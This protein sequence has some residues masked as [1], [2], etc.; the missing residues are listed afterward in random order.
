MIYNVIGVLLGEEPKVSRL[1]EILGDP[2]R[3]LFS[4]T[5]FR[6]EHTNGGVY[7]Y[8]NDKH[9]SASKII[10]RILEVANQPVKKSDLKF[11]FDFLKLGGETGSSLHARLNNLCDKGRIKFNN[12]YVELTP[13]GNMYLAQTFKVV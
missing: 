9:F 3:E 1:R 7:I 2:I 4:D 6:I 11:I 13:V 12:E 8:L 10:L 5:K